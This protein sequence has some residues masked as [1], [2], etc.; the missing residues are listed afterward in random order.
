MLV[1]LMEYGFVALALAVAIIYL[2]RY[3]S[4]QLRPGGCTDGRSSRCGCCAAAKDCGH[5]NIK[6]A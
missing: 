5:S 3:L 4:R 1:T 6:E 2:Y